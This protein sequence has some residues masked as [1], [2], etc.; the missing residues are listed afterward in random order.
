M[1]RGSKMPFSFSGRKAHLANSAP[2][3]ARCAEVSRQDICRW[4]HR[5]IGTRSIGAVHCSV[6]CSVRCNFFW[7]A[8][9]CMFFRSQ[10]RS[11]MLCG[12]A[13]LATFAPDVAWSVWVFGECDIFHVYARYVSARPTFNRYTAIRI[14]KRLVYNTAVCVTLQ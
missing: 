6:R 13:L 1:A 14:G 3:I 11:R 2:I 9:C 4:R 8:A 12:E 10:M 5:S 7:L